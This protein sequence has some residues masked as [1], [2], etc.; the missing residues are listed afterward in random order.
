M[1]NRT[2]TNSS[3]IN[4]LPVFETGSELHKF[5]ES[6][7][8]ESLKNLIKVTVNIMIKEEMD[9]FRKETTD[10]VSSMYF[11]GHYKR[12][13]TSAFGEIKNIPVPRFRANPQG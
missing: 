2:R 1:P 5:L 8:T 10:F 7:F 12:N 6:S 4:K 11:N 13:M 3:R 9:K